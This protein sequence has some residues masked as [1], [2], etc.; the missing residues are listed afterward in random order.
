MSDDYLNEV[1]GY[2]LFAW[3]FMDTAQMRSDPSFFVLMRDAVALCG[4]YP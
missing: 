4:R 3:S 2:G 1:T